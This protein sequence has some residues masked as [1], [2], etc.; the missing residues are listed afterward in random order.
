MG[1]HSGL[2]RFSLHSGPV[3]VSAELP[4]IMTPLKALVPGDDG[5]AGLARLQ[6]AGRSPAQSPG[7]ASET[8]LHHPFPKDSD[9]HTLRRPHPARGT[10]PQSISM[11]FFPSPTPQN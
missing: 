4:S 11:F 10:Q 2:Q 7:M 3:S 9:H 8:S 6:D 1:Q 5:E